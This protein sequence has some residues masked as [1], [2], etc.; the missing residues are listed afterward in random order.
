MR[1]RNTMNKYLLIL[2]NDTVFLK[3]EK[4][5]FYGLKCILFFRSVQCQRASVWF[6]ID[7]KYFKKSFPR[8][9]AGGLGREYVLRI[10]SVS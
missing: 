6:M 3:V 10:P 5:L 1:Q 7:L 2:M 4:G 9:D 8:E